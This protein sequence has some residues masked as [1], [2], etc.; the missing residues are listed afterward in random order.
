MEWSGLDGIALKSINISLDKLLRVQTR[1]RASDALS[2]WV[3]I[4]NAVYTSCEL[5]D[6]HLRLL[7]LL[8]FRHVGIVEQAETQQA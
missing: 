1:N 4:I 3:Y 7:V 5:S 8:Q 6:A 2:A